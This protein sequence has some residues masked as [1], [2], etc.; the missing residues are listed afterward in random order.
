MIILTFLFCSCASLLATDD[1]VGSLFAVT[2]QFRITNVTGKDVAVTSSHTRKTTHIPDGAAAVVP[3][4]V[5]D[6]SIHRDGTTWL[7]KKLSPLDFEGTPYKLFRSYHIPFG[8]GVV[9][10]NLWLDKDGRL[11]AVLPDAK[12]DPK[13]KKVDLKKLA[14]P[15]GFPAKPEEV[16]ESKK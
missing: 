2:V 8:G 10:V 15:K 13:N 14:Q 7:Y 4:A 9:T 16:K 3:H 12:L 6:I 11:Y 5:G 1:G